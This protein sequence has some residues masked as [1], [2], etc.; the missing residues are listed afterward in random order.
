MTLFKRI[1]YPYLL[2]E[3]LRNY[4]S[5]NSNGRLSI[6]YRYLYC[7]LHPLQQKFND[8][9]IIRIRQK[10][11]AGCKWERTQLLNVLN[12]LFPSNIGTIT[13]SESGT[14]IKFAPDIAMGNPATSPA[15]DYTFYSPDISMGDTSIPP[16]SDYTYFAPD[17]SA[18]YISIQFLT[19]IVPADVTHNEVRNVIDQINIGINYNVL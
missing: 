17:L 18:P 6:L 9:D 3:T 11:I 15:S 12:H 13:L 4:F 1:E 16:A 10:I 19:F 7:I 8:F 5:L 2:F 14:N